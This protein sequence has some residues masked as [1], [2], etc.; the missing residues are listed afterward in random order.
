MYDVLIVG[1]GPAGFT[2]ALYAA[3]AG[4]TVLVLERDTPGG[5]IAYAPRVENYPGMPGMSG[6][7]FAEQL[8]TQAEALGVEVDFAAVTGLSP[9]EG[10][11]AV[12]SEDG[13]HLARS[14]VLSPGASHRRLGLPGEE[15]LVG[16]GVSYCAVCDGAFCAG[17]R[18]VVVGGGNTALQDALFLAEIC[19]PVTLIHRREAFRADP[20]LVDR[21]RERENLSFLLGYVPTA[22]LQDAG[23]LTG[24]TVQNRETGEERALLAEGLFIAVGR[25]PGTAPF[26]RLVEVDEAGYFRAGE[27]C[28]TALP[29]IFVAGD[30]RKKSVRQL[31]TAVADGAVAG[32]AAAEFAEAVLCRSTR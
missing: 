10:G 13:M 16:A 24:L 26:S 2:A 5:Q 12:E 1:G 15:N 21:A 22:L 19:G 27:D 11:Y 23:A 7:A 30:C 6:A 4:R 9:A 25:T 29:G 3:R 14:L 8:Q 20:V 31:T 17:K 28:R 32:L 18:A